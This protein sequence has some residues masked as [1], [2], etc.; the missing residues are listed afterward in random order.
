MASA[1]DLVAH[2]SYEYVVAR[3]AKSKVLH[4]RF[5]DGF[6]CG[7]EDYAVIFCSSLKKDG[8]EQA[9]LCDMT[10]KVIYVLCDDEWKETLLHEIMHAVITE[11]G[12][13]QAPSYMGWNL[14]EVLCEVS[15]KT[16]RILL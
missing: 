6:R 3:S 2:E 7:V 9:G 8:E 4:K 5:K 14:E 16:L 15:S 1:Q 13:R 12:L 11:S 10:N